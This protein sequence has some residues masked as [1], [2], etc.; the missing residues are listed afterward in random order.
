MVG[1]FLSLASAA[2]DPTEHFLGGLSAAET[3]P[4]H[5]CKVKTDRFVD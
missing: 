2:K 4:K 3:K 1:H 5:G